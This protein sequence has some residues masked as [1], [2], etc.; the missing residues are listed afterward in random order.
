MKLAPTN[1]GPG[2]GKAS[3][4]LTAT[5]P[6]KAHCEHAV[7]ICVAIHTALGCKSLD[8][9]KKSVWSCG[10]NSNPGNVMDLLTML[11]KW[12]RCSMQHSSLHLSNPFH[13][14]SAH[15]CRD[16]LERL[17]PLRSYFDSVQYI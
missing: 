14:V 13:V 12:Q 2:Y 11:A 10:M 1:Y 5:D 15:C 9:L 4:M 6:L 7:D 3:Q 8:D 16:L 17:T